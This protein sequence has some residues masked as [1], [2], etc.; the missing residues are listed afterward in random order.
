MKMVKHCWGLIKQRPW[1]YF[2]SMAISIGFQLP[3]LASGIIAKDIFDSLTNNAK[4]GLGIEILVA[5]YLVIPLINNVAM[6]INSYII[7]TIDL[8]MKNILRKNMYSYF[9]K[10]PGAQT[11]KETVNE[12]L[13][14]FRDDVDDIVAFIIQP[15]YSMASIVF[16][17][18]AI[19]IMMKI[20]VI[21]TIIAVFPLLIVIVMMRIAQEHIRSFRKASRE[22]TGQIT[23]FIGEIFNS[24]H[25]I[26]IYA[27]E[28]SFMNYL[29][30]LCNKRR[31][32]TVKDKVLNG[33]FELTFLNL[34]YLAIGIILLFGSNLLKKG[35]FTVGD[36]A[37]FE[38]YF[39]FIRLLPASIGSF[40][41]QYK[42][43]NVSF[44]RITSIFENYSGTG[45]VEKK[46]FEST[47]S[48][49]TYLSPR[50]NG[51]SVKSVEVKGLTYIYPKTNRGIRDIDMTINKQT[52]TVISGKIGSGK[53][54]LVRTLLGLL[55]K[56]SGE[57]Y[58]NGKQVD[59][60]NYCLK[61][62]VCAY[63]PQIPKLFSGTIRENILV[64]L[65]EGKVDME[66]VLYLSA[67]D[68]D[69]SEF[70]NGL[71]TVIGNRGAKLSGGQQKRVALARTLARSSE[72]IIIDDFSSALD[73][74]TEQL[75][76]ERLIIPKIYT[77]VLVSNRV[78]VLKDA[79]SIIVLNNGIIS[80]KGI[81]SDFI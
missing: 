53:T 57:I 74:P 50:T 6:Q 66:K 65:E 71:D 73:A 7:S 63:T 69:I 68:R 9:L 4:L 39:W 1:L 58:V 41:K 14:H 54:V 51:I 49:V 48:V 44:S 56:D 43:S 13:T 3:L 30:Y 76:L 59:D 20:N 16:G 81:Y 47:E 45:L 24:V 75:I 78:R 29:E 36:F 2:I 15:I 34:V 62:P 46:D 79:D 5:L 60:V 27:Y 72:I 70:D 23:Y 33:F 31:I 77:C 67:L 19:I 40:L 26:K 25:S 80:K 35:K 11:V 55:K 42:Q 64:G 8:T 28:K 22:S 12:T 17:I 32:Q 10:M 61:P 21:L 52:L 38:Y 37:M 18:F